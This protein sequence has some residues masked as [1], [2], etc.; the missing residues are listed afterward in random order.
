LESAKG[1]L[2]ASKIASLLTAKWFFKDYE[3]ACEKITK[4]DIL[5][6]TLI[7]STVT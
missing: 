3:K 7:S 6:K 5:R 2:K 1:T 4:D